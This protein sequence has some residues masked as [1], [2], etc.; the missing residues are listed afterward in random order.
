MFDLPI[1]SFLIWLPIVGGLGVLIV[2]DRFGAKQFALG[3]A[4]EIGRAHV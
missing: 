3:V 2:G 4:L 1:L